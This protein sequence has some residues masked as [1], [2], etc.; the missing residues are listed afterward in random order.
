MGIGGQQLQ[1]L[2]SRGQTH[3]RRQR[4]WSAAMPS[5]L[6]QLQHI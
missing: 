2:H 1:E 4:G 3:Q 6:L 5:I